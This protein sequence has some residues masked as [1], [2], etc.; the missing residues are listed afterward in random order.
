MGSA[1]FR[2]A[3]CCASLSAAGLAILELVLF[4]L[5]AWLK[6]AAFLQRSLEALAEGAFTDPED[7]MQ[8]DGLKCS[9]CGTECLILTGKRNFMKLARLSMP[10]E[11]KRARDDSI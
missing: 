4:E 7:G 11:N 3:I 10:V 2:S 9:Q 5:K 8:F 1:C 6:R